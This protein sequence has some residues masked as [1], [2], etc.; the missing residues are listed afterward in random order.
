LPKAPT[1]I[2][3]VRA[4]AQEALGAGDLSV[5]VVA[6]QLGVAPRTLQRRLAEAHDTTFVAVVDE[7]RAEL[8]EQWLVDRELSV[9]EIAF[10]LGFADQSAFHRA[11]VRWTGRTPGQVRRLARP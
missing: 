5:T 8:A 2:A 4:A 10:A 3:Q 11:F 7:L 6:R 1:L 9:A